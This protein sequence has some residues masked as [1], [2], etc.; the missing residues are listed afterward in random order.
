MLSRDK[1]EDVAKIRHIAMTTRNVR[2][3][4][5]FFK[6]AFGMVEIPQRPNSPVEAATL[7]DGY[8]NVTVLGWKEDR[9]GGGHPGLHHFGFHV[10]DL[11]AA[12]AT[13]TEL[14]AHELAEH[15]KAY[16]NLRGTPEKWVGE[17][18]W[19]TPDG[20]AIDVNPT[21]WVIRPGGE[22]GE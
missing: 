18:K 20:M 12:E 4:A 7:S 8:I 19:L 21:G 14:G 16:G 22:P 3:T 10:E 1:G 11:D 2:A 17:K 6:Q 9:Y 13:L 5:E 15:N